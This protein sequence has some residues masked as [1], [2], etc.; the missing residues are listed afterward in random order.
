MAG[1]LG[2][3]IYSLTLGMPLEWVS[4]SLE[5][6]PLITEVFLCQ[7]VEV[8]M[9]ALTALE[10]ELQ[11]VREDQDAAQVEKEALEQVQNTLVQVVME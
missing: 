2:S 5:P 6:P 7:Q 1:P 3:H 8:L 9:A 10:G 11:W 4:S